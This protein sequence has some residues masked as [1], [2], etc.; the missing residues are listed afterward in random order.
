MSLASMIQP[1]VVAQFYHAVLTVVVVLITIGLAVV[2]IRWVWRLIAE[3][4]SPSVSREDL[5]DRAPKI[6]GKE[7]LWRALGALWVL[8]GLLQL[9][10]AM[11]NYAFLEMVIAPNLLGQPGWV[12]RVMGWGIQAWSNALITADVV[13]VFVQLGIGLALLAGR[14]RPWGRWAL[15]TSLFWGLFVWILGEGMGGILT[16]QASLVIG[17]PGSVLF[18]MAS[19]GL[20]LLPDAMWLAG[21]VRRGVR[22]GVV[23]LWLWG[24]LVQ[25]WPG[26]GFWSG[27]ALG[28]LFQ[29]AAQNA[30]PLWLSGPIYATAHW[31][32]HH[33]LVANGVIVGM[34]S[35][36]ALLWAWRPYGRGTMAVTMGW[37]GV[38][39]WLGQDFGV[40]GGVGTDPN[41]APVF[42]LLLGTAAWSQ[43]PLAD[44]PALR[45]IPWFRA[46]RG[47]ETLSVE[48][49]RRV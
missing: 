28:T 2:L 4:E 40:L 7:G 34:M 13:A 29:N 42:A 15:W 47:A 27:P 46:K 21:Q 10:P 9:Q 20:L 24:A 48:R 22:W 1:E 35:L 19:A 3:S 30:Q 8:D 25:A 6:W 26:A 45:F 32:T 14:W 11:P 41:T 18:Y 49:G 37:L 16:G 39:W 44:V 12:V 5:C 43:K 31:V 38:L 17:D 36:L 33:G 23:G